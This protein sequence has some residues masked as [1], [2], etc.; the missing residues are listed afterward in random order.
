[1][2]QELINYAHGQNANKHIIQWIEKRIKEPF[3]LS[4]SE[5][6]VDYLVSDKAPSR[7]TRA[8]YNQ[9]K[10][11][12]DKWTNSLQKKGNNIIEDKQDTKIILNFK[13]GFK[14]VQLIGEN[15]YKREGMLMRHCC[16]NYYGKDVEVYSLR[17]KNNKPHCTI[18]KDVQIKGKGNGDISPK[19]INYVV[20]FLEWSGMKVRDSEMQNLGYI[21]PKFYRYV[22]N[23]LYK[24]KYLRKTEAV[25]YKD[26]VKI[27]TS[28]D[29]LIKYSGKKICLLDTN[30]AIKQNADLNITGLKEVGGYVNV[31]ENAKFTAPVLTKCGSVYVRENAKFTAPVLKE[32]GYSVNVRENAKFTAPVLT[33]CGSVNVG[34]N[35]KFTAPVLKEVG[36]SVDVGENAKFT[37]PVLTKCGS[38]NVG[39]NA[40]F[41]APVLKEV[42]GSVDVW[43]NAKFTAPVL[44]E[45]GGYVDVGENAKFTAPVLTKCG[46]VYVGENAKFTA[47]VLTKCGSVYVRENAKFTAPVLKEVGGSVD[48]W[49]NAKFT[50]PVL[51]YEK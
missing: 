49:K 14:I 24:N 4:E 35:A 39:E 1:M 38:V 34:E 42:G 5:H 33:K 47:P 3:D 27:F 31:G 10:T 18:E 46:S 45:V 6:I 17:D 9:M 28:L 12:A 29:E 11:N 16:A 30:I 8:T 2:K 22:E 40:K 48:V 20:G 44:K 13:D 23:K 7:L 21:V 36:Y 37:A 43:K 32:V 15:A 19:Y 25:V 41:T 26:N 50:A 51:K